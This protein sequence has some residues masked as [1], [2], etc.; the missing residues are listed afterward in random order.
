MS[1]TASTIASLSPHKGIQEAKLHA[2]Y[3][4]EL[5]S[6]HLDHLR[7]LLNLLNYLAHFDSRPHFFA[8]P[9]LISQSSASQEFQSVSPIVREDL[10]AILQDE[11]FHLSLDTSTSPSGILATLSH[12]YT[13]HL[14]PLV[15]ILHQPLLISDS[16]ISL[17]SPLLTL[18]PSIA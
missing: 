11:E 5:R 10:F 17:L 7:P 15:G 2:S 13:T 9:N 3:T 4:N 8:R 1:G 6:L 14:L 16:S 12:Q 18:A